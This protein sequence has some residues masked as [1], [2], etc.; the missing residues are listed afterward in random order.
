MAFV[1]Q[2]SSPK[3][4]ESQEKPIDPEKDA[5]LPSAAMNLPTNL[6]LVVRVVVID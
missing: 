1:I 6:L 5:L 3:F 4:T 2:F